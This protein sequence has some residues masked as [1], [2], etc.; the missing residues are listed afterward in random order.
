MTALASEMRQSSRLKRQ[1]FHVEAE[2]VISAHLLHQ[3]PKL[4]MKPALGD[5]GA[6]AAP[7]GH[8]A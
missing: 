7:A 4:P 1:V 3:C 2:L 6:P 8:K 5:P